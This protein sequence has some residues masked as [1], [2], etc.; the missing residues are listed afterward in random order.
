MQR[1]IGA[2]LNGEPVPEDVRASL[3]DEERAEAARIAATAALTQT[4]LQAPVPP[5]QAEEASLRRAQEMVSRQPVPPQ[6]ENQN[7]RQPS[8]QGRLSGWLARWRRKG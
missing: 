6:I 1:V 4:V 5:P 2:L 3:T 8:P 7:P